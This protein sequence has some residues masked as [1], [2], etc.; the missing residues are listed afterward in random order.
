[1]SSN[2]N[3]N[4]TTP[5]RPKEIFV[6]DADTANTLAKTP[7]T[8][9]LQARRRAAVLDSE[10]GRSTRGEYNWLA[11]LSTSFISTESPLTVSPRLR[12]LSPATT[13]TTANVRN[14]FPTSMASSSDAAEE[15]HHGGLESEVQSVHQNNMGTQED[16]ED[17]PVPPALS[18]DV[19]DGAK[20]QSAVESLCGDGDEDSAVSDEVPLETL[21][22]NAPYAG[23]ADGALEPNNQALVEGEVI[24]DP[25]RVEDTTLILMEAMKNKRYVKHSYYEFE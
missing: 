12:S 3:N 9:V 2:N 21:L 8:T 20:K 19:S 25:S 16:Q 24:A 22:A 15:T 5:S 17:E 4:N 11:S 23:V 13:G 14:L 6:P 18:V 7:A 10:R 1:M